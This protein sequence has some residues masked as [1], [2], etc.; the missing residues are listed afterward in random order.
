[1]RARW[2]KPSLS[3]SSLF[4]VTAFAA[5][6]GTEFA[7]SSSECTG[8]ACAGPSPVDAGT[9]AEAG[10]VCDPEMDPK[11]HPACV[12]DAFGVFVDKDNGNDASAGTKAA[13]LKSVSAALAKLNGKRRVFLCKGNYFEH[14]TI[15]KPVSIH[16][17]FE[18]ESWVYDGSKA[19]F[20]PN[21]TGYILQVALVTEPVQVS[22]LAL[23]AVD[24]KTSGESSIAAF[25]TRSAQVT[26]R[27][28]SIT[29]GAG[30]PGADGADASDYVPATAPDGYAGD[31]PDQ[32]GKARQNQGCTT[33][34]G[35]AGGR[36]DS[37]SG[38]AGQVSLLPPF[39]ET[40]TGAGGS[41]AADCTSGGAG[42][43]GS[44]GVG[45]QQGA[46]AAIFGT[47]DTAGWKGAAGMP[48]GKGG[49]GQGG[50]GGARIAPTGV[51]GGGGPG[52]CGGAGGAFGSAGGSSIALLV[53]DSAVT[54]ESSVLVAKDGGNGGQG[55]KGQRAQLGSASGG[56]PNAGD[57]A[58]AGGLGG[59]G[60]SGGGGGG[61]AGGL[62]AGILYQGPAPVIDGASTPAAD[63]LP[64]VTLGAAGA[65]G[66]KGLGG[67]AARSTAPASRA[68]DDGTPGVDGVAKA[69]LVVP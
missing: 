21:D 1:M 5:A 18:C 22:D 31:D 40:N 47:L 68:G 32:P 43:D 29:A 56:A 10:P 61:G 20:A 38:R 34:I 53:F 48:G 36:D 17:G 57:S 15:T 52:G 26:L 35:G 23:E 24:G 7:C 63:T 8:G 50:G 59:A 60:G 14:V 69:V 44:Y 16:G 28:M 27:R 64:F 13:P 19:R 33:S 30:V 66:A 46:G 4:L 39:P 41:E 62:S 2:L 45:G 3:R 49:D 25:V 42:A 67:E 11:D 65:G 55:G 12:D 37:P 6:A 9:E 58:C 51:G 54:V